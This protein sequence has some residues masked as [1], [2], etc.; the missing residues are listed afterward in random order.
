MLTDN[1]NKGGL[2]FRDLECFNVALL[3]KQCWRILKYP[4]SPS[5]MLLKSIYFSHCS[6][7][8]AGTGFR[9]S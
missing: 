7:L 9:P 5:A 6:F 1:K 8:E 4:S 2:G 3:A